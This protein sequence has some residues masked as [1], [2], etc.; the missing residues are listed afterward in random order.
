MDKIQIV[1]QIQ[2]FL[3]RTPIVGEEAAT[4]VVCKQ[5]V[6]MQERAA[7]IITSGPNT[8][9]GQAGDPPPSPPQVAD[10]SGK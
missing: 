1:R 10:T 2:R 3:D 8:G 9:P 4:M 5:W 6:T 7:S